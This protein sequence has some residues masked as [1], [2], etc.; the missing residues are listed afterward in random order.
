M[1]PIGAVNSSYSSHLTSNS[2][3]LHKFR[4][5]H[6]K[7]T[8]SS[9]FQCITL[10]ILCVRPITNVFSIVRDIHVVKPSRIEPWSNYTVCTAKWPAAHGACVVLC[11]VVAGAYEIVSQ[12]S[13]TASYGRIRF[14]ESHPGRYLEVGQ[15]DPI[16]AKTGLFSVRPSDKMQETSKNGV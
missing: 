13:C 14:Y 4:C 7:V 2:L 9:L 8:K 16:S 1:G 11:E 3:F 5:C 6:H 12:H 15:S 10:V